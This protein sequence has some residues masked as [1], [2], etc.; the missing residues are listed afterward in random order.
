MRKTG[1]EL[2]GT[3]PEEFEICDAGFQIFLALS[4]VLN[5]NAA[6]KVTK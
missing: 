6:I 3:L 2:A 5:F 4:I 1:K